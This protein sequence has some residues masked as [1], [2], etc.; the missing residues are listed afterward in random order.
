MIFLLFQVF[1]DNFFRT[2]FC[3][4]KR[5]QVPYLWA[6]GDS[7]NLEGKKVIKKRRAQFK[8]QNKDIKGQA[9]LEYII[10]SSL[11]GIFCLFAMKRIGQ[12]LE[13][14]LNYIKTSITKNLPMDK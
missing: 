1:T 8:K 14:R 11:I 5:K 9:T 12:V 2:I 4:R 3:K 10:I 6:S 13:K 7:Q